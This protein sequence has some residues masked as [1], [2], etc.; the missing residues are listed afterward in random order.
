MT[1]PPAHVAGSLA[2]HARGRT[3]AASFGAVPSRQR[4]PGG[5]LLVLATEFQTNVGLARDWLEWVSLP[6]RLLVIAPPFGRE[7]CA[8]PVRWEARRTEPLAGGETELGKVLANERRH[9]IRGQLLPL[10]RH[11][12]QIVTGGWRKHPAA[13]LVAITA[14]P[15][16]SLTALDHRAACAAWLSDLL[17][18]AG[19]P[20]TAPNDSVRAQP[21]RDLSA[22]EW[23][24]LL[25]LCAGPYAGAREALR[26]LEASRIHYLPAQRA[27]LALN[28]LTELGLV[29]GGAL[30][31]AGEQ[32]LKTGPYAPY[33]EAL[34]RMA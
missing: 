31:S 6:G 18:Q 13:G 2:V 21:F 8:V 16:W 17:R 3:L 10:E 12:G 11:A 7:P 23:T 24:V 1:A 27:E 32:H 15:L 33:A 9:E 30:T 34:R 5:S 28:G 4:P 29:A 25:H 20:A 22:D 19:R 14:L 26:A